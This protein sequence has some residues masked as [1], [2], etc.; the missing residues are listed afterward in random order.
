ME[1]TLMHAPTYDPGVDRAWHT[2]L[3]ELADDF[4]VEGARR[5][6]PPTAHI[7]RMPVSRPNAFLLPT[8]GVPE[9]GQMAMGSLPLSTWSI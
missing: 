4:I 3:G 6:L 2:R 5:C 1:T 9:I 7:A 8:R